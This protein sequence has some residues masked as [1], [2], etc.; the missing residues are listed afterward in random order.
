VLGG[1]V[2]RQY[3]KQPGEHSSPAVV[4]CAEHPA[5]ELVHLVVLRDKHFDD[6]LR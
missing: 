3:V 5:E 1:F 2:Q 6:V 4:V